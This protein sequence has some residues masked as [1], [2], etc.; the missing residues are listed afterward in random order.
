MDDGLVRGVSEAES[1]MLD[2][3]GFLK[4]QMRLT[5]SELREQLVAAR[6]ES[7]DACAELHEFKE[8]HKAVKT[9]LADSTLELERLHRRLDSGYDSASSQ[10]SPP[11][12]PTDWP[13]EFEDSSLN[14]SAPLDSTSEISSEWIDGP[15]ATQSANALHGLYDTSFYRTPGSECCIPFDTQ[16]QFLRDSLDYAGCVVWSVLLEKWP[17]L[18]REHYL[19][20]SQSIKYGVEDRVGSQMRSG[21]PRSQV[22]P[23]EAL[24]HVRLLRNAAYHSTFMDSENISLHLQAAQELTVEFGEPLATAYVRMLRN[25]LIDEVKKAHGQIEDGLPA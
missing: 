4:E 5:I 25:Q 9:Q 13:S 22:A 19:H 24:E 7:A 2:V 8:V 11:L 15:N 14:W 10:W 18:L 1:P 23:M 12:A 21:V 6:R 16:I 3:E 20:G 17:E